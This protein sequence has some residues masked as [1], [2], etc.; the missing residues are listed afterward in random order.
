MITRITIKGYR[1]FG[2]FELRPNAGMNIIV[3]DND[4]GKST[5]LEAIGLALTGRINNGWAQ[6]ALDPYW[7]N[8]DQVNAFFTALSTEKKLPPP[9]ILIEIY[10]S[11]DSHGLHHLWYPQLTPRGCAR[12]PTA[13]RAIAGVPPGD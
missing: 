4:S 12:H 10:L 1:I 2:D 8:A 6:D 5:L 3:G 9:E 13:D 7:F 11:P